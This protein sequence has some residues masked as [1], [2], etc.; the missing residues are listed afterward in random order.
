MKE[1]NMKIQASKILRLRGSV[2]AVSAKVGETEPLIP[3][4]P[5]PQLPGP[6]EGD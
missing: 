1:K 2:A 5:P 3:D 6:I 4:G